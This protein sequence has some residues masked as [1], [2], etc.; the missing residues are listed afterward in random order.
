MYRKFGSRFED[1]A[2]ALLMFQV[3]WVV[4][5]REYFL[6]FQ[7]IILPSYSESVS[8]RRMTKLFNPEEE[9]TVILKNIV[10]CTRAPQC[11]IP[12]DLNLQ[13]LSV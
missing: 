8:L 7:R 4:T 12:K 9:D 2:V 5:L 6:G 3:S 10:N 1:S 11:H 13:T